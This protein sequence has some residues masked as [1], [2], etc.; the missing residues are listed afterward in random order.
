MKL[1]IIAENKTD[2]VVIQFNLVKVGINVAVE[3]V[4]S[5]ALF[6]CFGTLDIVPG[7]KEFSEY[8]HEWKK[9]RC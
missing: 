6:D 4:E 7:E 5:V 2:A 9:E 3:E 1:V 8:L